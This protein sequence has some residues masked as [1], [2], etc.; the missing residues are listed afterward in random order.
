ML[1]FGHTAVKRG[2]AT[3]EHHA[4]VRLDTFPEFSAAHDASTRAFVVDVV[5]D[6]QQTARQRFGTLDPC[7][8]VS[9]ASYLEHGRPVASQSPYSAL[10]EVDPRDLAAEIGRRG[11]L[12]ARLQFLHDG[13][14]AACGLPAA[15]T[16]QTVVLLGTALG[17]GL[18]PASSAGDERAG[19]LAYARGSFG[20]HAQFGP[21]ELRVNPSAE[22]AVRAGH[23]ILTPDT[24]N[25]A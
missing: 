21:G 23:H 25:E 7:V 11:G 4:L 6:T 12:R 2:V 18:R 20:Q 15:R 5:T 9:I 17:V 24:L 1:D 3:F 8:L 14:A 10:S 19:R 13:T 16:R 22:P